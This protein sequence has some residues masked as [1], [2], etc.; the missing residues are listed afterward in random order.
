MK[1]CLIG[2]LLIVS[3]FFTGCSKD[4]AENVL[5]DL[6]KKVNNAKAYQVQGSLEISNNDDTYH[7]DVVAA[8]KEKDQYRVSLKN[9]ANNHEQIILKNNDGVY[10][11]THKSTQLL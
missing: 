8:Y 6:E 1:K 10:V 3:L 4:G 11:M 2:L 5:K 7:Y 9:K